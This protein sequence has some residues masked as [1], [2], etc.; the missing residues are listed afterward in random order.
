MSHTQLPLKTTSLTIDEVFQQAVTYHQ[1][2]HLHDAEHLYRIT[3]ENQPGHSDAQ[4]NLEVLTEQIEQAVAGL[5]H[6]KAALE[7]NTDQAQYWFN[8]IDALILTNQTEL[9]QQVLRLGKQH[10]LQGEMVSVLAKRLEYAALRSTQL[11]NQPLTENALSNT[12]TFCK[13]KSNISRKKTNSNKKSSLHQGKTP[14]KKQIDALVNYFEKGHYNETVT[15]SRKMTASYPY[16]DFG[17][18]MLGTVL[19]QIGRDVEA[20]YPLEKAIELSSNDAETLNNLG[21]T[22][23][24]LGQNDQAEAS[25]RRALEIK[26]DLAEAHNTLGAILLELGRFSEAETSHRHA[27]EIRPNYVSAMNNL[28]NVF[29]EQCLLD[30]AEACYRQ[31]LTINPNSALAHNNL[32]YILQEQGE[33]NA[34]EECYRQS[35]KLQ[36][37]FEFA[38]GN[39]LFALNY[40]PDKS[41]K[42]IFKAYQEYNTKYCL[43]HHS[44]WRPHNNNPNLQRR[45]KVGYVSPDFRKHSVQYFLEP[46][47]AHHDNQVVEMYAYAELTEEDAVT[48]RYKSYVD[49]WVPT[50]GISNAALAER[51]R[52]DGIDILVDLAG[53]TAKNRLSVFARKPAPVSVSWLGYGYTTGLT[54]IDYFLTDLTTVPHDSE[55]LFSETPYRLTTPSFSYRPAEGMGD[56]NDLPALTNGS[57][58]FGTLTRAVRLNYRTIRVWSEILKCV[59]N[60][61]LVIDSK[62]FSDQYMRDLFIEKFIAHGITPERL[63]LGYHTPPWDVL[64]GIDI[65]LDCFPHNSGATLFETLYMGVPYITLAG[66]SSVGRL[67]SCILQ[68]LGH[69]EWIAESEADYVTKAVELASDINRLSKIR[70]GMRSQM[71]NSPLRDEKNFAL[72]VEAAYRDIWK[73]WCQTGH[74][75]DEK[76]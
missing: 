7:A 68:G 62:V 58:T 6:F 59:P 24:A 57:I 1:A 9:A 15:L 43:P 48:S 63:E 25:C 70:A 51:I 74:H 26:P 60:S 42:E 30:K 72:K 45:L 67:G 13:K 49:H 69:R 12:Q 56:I 55:A 52:A 18:K 40:H 38:F 35:L 10:G 46:L 71:E 14:S 34:A 20:L 3:L 36:P 44:E 73:K 33:I 76:S 19:K 11:S 21:I 2:G 64:R 39:L 27:L 31:A 4:H 47:L 61:R 16:Y 41:A 37:D 28:G 5:S 17:W 22:Y 29:K 54:A 23:K 66:R 32:G 75:T 65:G 8:Y 53:H 50:R